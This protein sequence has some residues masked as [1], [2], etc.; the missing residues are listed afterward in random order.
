MGTIVEI[1]GG[2]GGNEA[3]LFAAD[4]YRT[5]SDMHAEARG[6]KIEELE[7]KPL[8]AWVSQKE[9]IFR[10]ERTV[11]TFGFCDTK[12]VAVTSIAATSP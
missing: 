9:I 6:F 7:S 11:R 5:Y 4:L 3:A 10:A 1:R 2:T 8:R 12:A